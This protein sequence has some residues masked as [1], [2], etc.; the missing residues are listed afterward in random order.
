MTRNSRAVR[1]TIIALLAMGAT[2][3]LQIMGGA[4][5]PLVPP[6]L[7]LP[8]AA[9]ALLTWRP[10]LWTSLFALA[11]GLWIGF[12]AIVAPEAGEHLRSGGNLLVASTVAQLVTL[13]AIVAGGAVLL[14]QS[15]RLTR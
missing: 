1:F 15:R 6:G 5:Y 12:G 11:N 14:A 7:V 13:V 8:L 3:V 2:I 9:A 10:N 4:D